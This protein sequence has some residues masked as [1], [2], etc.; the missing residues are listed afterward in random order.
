VRRGPTGFLDRVDTLSQNVAVQTLVGFDLLGDYNFD[1]LGGN[2]RLQYVGT[3]TTESDFTAFDGDSPLECAGRFGN[4]CGQPL[5]EYKHRIAAT[6]GRDSLTAQVVWR[7]IGEVDDDTDAKDFTVETIDAESY[8][9][10]SVQYTL[11]AGLSLQAGVQ[12]LFDVDPPVLGGNA[13]QANTWPA[14]YDVF[15][16]TYFLRVGYSF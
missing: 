2:I 11:D 16:R 3:Y 5:P 10:G 14:T 1:A 7:Y 15:G 4:N 6:Y 12:N 9:D 13:Q 8:I